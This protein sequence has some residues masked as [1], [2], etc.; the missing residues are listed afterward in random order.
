MNVNVTRGDLRD[1]MH[2]T[3]EI[4]AGHRIEI[5]VPELREGQQ[6]DVFVVPH[7]DEPAASRSLLD[8]LDRLPLGPRSATTWDEVERRF[9]EKRDAWDR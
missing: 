1:A 4:Q 8:F 6:V 7:R 5:N 9:Q 2:V 3:A